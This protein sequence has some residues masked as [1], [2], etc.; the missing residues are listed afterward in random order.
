M[1]CGLRFINVAGAAGVKKKK[2]RP[3]SHIH[4]RFLNV[5]AILNAK[6]PNAN[7]EI[8]KT[9]QKRQKIVEG[10]YAIRLY[11]SCVAPN[12]RFGIIG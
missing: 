6:F 12:L 8:G 11:R 10:V 9:R 3:L 2:S 5:N 4:R 7:L 1:S